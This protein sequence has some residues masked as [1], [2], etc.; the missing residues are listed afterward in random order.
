M[1]N[2]KKEKIDGDKFRF[3]LSS[4]RVGTTSLREYLKENIRNIDVAFEPKSSRPAFMLWNMENFLKINNSL[5]ESYVIRQ[6]AK[7]FHKIHSGY[8]R[9]EINPF[10]TPF[11]KILTEN[12]ENMHVVHIV[13]HPYT[14]INSIMNFRALGWNKYVIDSIPF[15]RLMH[16]LAINMWS[17]LTEAEKFAWRWRLHNEQILEEINNYSVYKV[18]K[19]EDLS[20]GETDTKVD[21]LSEILKIL[22]PD[23]DVS[24][25]NINKL[26]KFNTSRPSK[27][28]VLDNLSKKARGNIYEICEPLMKIFSYGDDL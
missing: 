1:N 8:T 6:R 9:I 28:S 4:G 11:C 3:L 10:L 18:F 15:T 16:P 17:A 24:K 26:G 22:V 21:N 12:I 5:S 25:I 2:L 14:W 20:L 27:R 7:E 19:Y 13:R 23:Y